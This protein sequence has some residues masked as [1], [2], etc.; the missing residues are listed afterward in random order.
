VARKSKLRDD[1]IASILCKLHTGVAAQTIMRHALPH[2][3]LEQLKQLDDELTWAEKAVLRERRERAKSTLELAKKIAL[4][5]YDELHR[6]P[7]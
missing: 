1:L 7:T 3:S 2:C 6:S 4:R 5:M